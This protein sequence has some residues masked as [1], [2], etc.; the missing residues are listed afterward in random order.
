[1]TTMSSPLPGVTGT[2]PYPKAPVI[3]KSNALLCLILNVLLPGIGTIAGG[4]MGNMKL[5]GRGIAQ[6]LLAFLV[7]GWIWAV[8]TGIQMLQNATW[9]E[10]TGG[11]RPV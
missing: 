6:L 5:I 7:V 1:M 8:V 9:K 4:V 10:S 11:G 2:P 3:E